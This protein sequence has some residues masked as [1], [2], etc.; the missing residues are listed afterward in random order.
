MKTS[1]LIT[2]FSGLILSAATAHAGLYA[3]ASVVY[4]DIDSFE[5]PQ[6]TSSI[7]T[8]LDS[9]MGYSGAIGYKFTLLRIEGEFLY[10]KNDVDGAEG[11]FNA[12]GDLS[13]TNI[14][15]NGYL[16]LPIVPFLKPYVG[17]GIGI[18]KV[19]V[20]NMRVS[21]TAGVLYRS[22]DNESAFG[23]Q[24]MA[25]IRADLP[26][27]ELSLYAGYRYLSLEQIDVSVQDIATQTYLNLDSGNSH[28]FELG[29]IYGF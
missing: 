25:G 23:Y 11:S 10:V 2:V 29:L 15:L 14:F 21:D 24:F 3:K 1:L 6:N 8:S 5:V 17:A 4:A 20:S 9:S 19:D 22:D 27:T 16:D 18:A 12:D 28:I 7:S 13:Q 26:I